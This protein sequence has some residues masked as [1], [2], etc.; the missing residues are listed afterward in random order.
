SRM[1]PLDK[2][3]NGLTFKVV[4]TGEQDDHV[5]S[6]LFSKD[7]LKGF[8][9]LPLLISESVELHHQEEGVGTWTGDLNALHYLFLDFLIG[10]FGVKQAWGVDHCDMSVIDQSIHLL[11]PSAGKAADIRLVLLGRRGSG[12][13]SCGNT[14]LGAKVF[15]SFLST[16]P[17]TREC[18]EHSTHIQGRKTQPE[19]RNLVEKCGDRYHVFNNRDTSSDTQVTDLLKMVNNIQSKHKTFQSKQPSKVHLDSSEDSQRSSKEKLDE[20][21]KKS[22]FPCHLF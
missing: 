14:I 1:G 22:F 9:T 15:Q 3:M 20:R 12:K 13:S 7:L 17:V 4:S 16:T 18:E 5:F 21:R 8:N 10:L 2:V 11:A 6:G 19:L